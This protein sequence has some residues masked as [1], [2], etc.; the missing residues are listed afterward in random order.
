MQKHIEMDEPEEAPEL[1]TTLF[2][3]AD[4]TGPVISEDE[5]DE[6]AIEEEVEEDLLEVE[7]E[8][9]VPGLTEVD[10][11]AAEEEP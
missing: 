3:V 4:P 9:E 1:E 2:G 6:E 7:D 5:V 8:D 11:E 10:G